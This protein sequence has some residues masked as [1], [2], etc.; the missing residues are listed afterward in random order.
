MDSPLF[1]W[2]SGNALLL[3]EGGS[4][5]FKSIALAAGTVRALQVPGQSTL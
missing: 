4:G 3:Q 2:E 1:E 5:A